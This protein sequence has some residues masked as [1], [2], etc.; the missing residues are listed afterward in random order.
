MS[1]TN[2]EQIGTNNEKYLSN[3]LLREMNIFFGSISNE[4]ETKIL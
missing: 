4:N 2:L 1:C 3:Y